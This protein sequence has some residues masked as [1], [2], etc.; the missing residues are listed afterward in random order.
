MKDKDKKFSLEEIEKAVSDFYTKPSPEERKIKMITF[1]GGYKLF[2]EAM[3]KHF[4]NG[5]CEVEQR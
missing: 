2:C 5:Y 1:E 3:K 4:E